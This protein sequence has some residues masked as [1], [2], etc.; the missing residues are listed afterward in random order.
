MKESLT[1]PQAVQQLIVD[2]GLSEGLIIIVQ[3]LNMLKFRL[4][5]IRL[6]ANAMR[7]LTLTRSSGYEVVK[8]P[9]PDIKTQF[10]AAL[11]ENKKEKPSPCGSC[12]FGSAAIILGVDKKRCLIVEAICSKD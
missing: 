1:A 5:N 4:S 9:E 11:R 8:L 6:A 3:E 10:M 7:C 12:R 2:K